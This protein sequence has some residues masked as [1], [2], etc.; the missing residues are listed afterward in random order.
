MCKLSTVMMPLAWVG[1][2]IPEDIV[3]AA[4]VGDSFGVAL[5]VEQGKVGEQSLP[6]ASQITLG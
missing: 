3:T 5:R 2:L 6:R 4:I 1:S